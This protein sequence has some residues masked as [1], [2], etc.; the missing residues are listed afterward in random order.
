MLHV[1]GEALLSAITLQTGY[2]ST[3]SNPPIVARGAMQTLKLPG[4]DF[5]HV[6][7]VPME[8][9]C[10]GAVMLVVEWQGLRLLHTGDMR[11][12]ARHLERWRTNPPLWAALQEPDVMHLDCTFAAVYQVRLCACTVWLTIARAF[13]SIK[14]SLRLDKGE[15]VPALDT[16]FID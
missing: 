6:T 16:V 3:H 7:A 5:L 14:S 13:I 9:H 11:V 1:R 4:G 10:P 2:C 12:E 8:Q 15:Y